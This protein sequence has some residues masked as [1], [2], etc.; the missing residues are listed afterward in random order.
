MSYSFDYPIRLVADPDGGFV[1]TVRDLPEVVTQGE[2]IEEALSEAADAIEE[3][4]AGR[5]R[6]G[7]EIPAPSAL[8]KGEHEASPSGLVAIKAGLYLA[9]RE[10][11]TTQTDLSR[12]LG[13]DEKEVRRLLDPHHSSKLSRLQDALAALGKRLVLQVQDVTP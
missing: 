10:S 7:A 13:C 9:L 11:R 3:A 6:R 4:L 12:Q 8:R 5:M 1:V 2:S